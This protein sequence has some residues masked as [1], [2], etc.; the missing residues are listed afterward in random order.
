ME[1]GLY[2]VGTPIGNLED[3]TF[4]AVRVLQEVDLILAE[5]TRKTGILLKHFE[6]QTSMMSCHKFNEQSRVERVLAE[7]EAGKSLA[8][9]SDAGMPLISDP[10]SRLVRAVRDA[11]YLVT[12]IP[13]PTA[14]TTALA[15]SGWGDDGFV[16]AGFPPNKSAGR[17]RM[18]ES[19]QEETRPVILYESTH[20]IVKCMRD[21]AEVLGDRPV[22]FARELTKKFETLFSGTATDCADFLEERSSKG[23]FV[24]ILGPPEKTK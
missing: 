6:I 18:L 16:F 21:I 19:F 23:E 20:R 2:L 22:F 5:D 24:V 17:K 7:L 11:G 14:V 13:G 10:G 12:A 15:L 4:R 1:C 8:L 3:M 9:V